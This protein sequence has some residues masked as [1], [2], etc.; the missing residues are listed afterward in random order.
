MNDFKEM[1]GSIIFGSIGCLFQKVK[2]QWNHHT[3][4]TCKANVVVRCRE[5][6]AVF[7]YNSTVEL[8]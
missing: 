3:T 8:F 4:D 1:K 5:V 2:I 6:S 7:R